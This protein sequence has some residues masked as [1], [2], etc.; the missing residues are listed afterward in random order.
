MALNHP[1]TIEGVAILDV[2][3]TA[4]AWDRADARLL[5][6]FWPWALLAQ[7]TPLP[8]RPALGG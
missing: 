2:V 8:E 7:P 5:L 4:T 1:N 3:P 6:A